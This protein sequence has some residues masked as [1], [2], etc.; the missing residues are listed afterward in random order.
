LQ[1]LK[2]T[3][4]STRTTI[5]MVTHDLTAAQVGHRLLWL[6]DGLIQRDESFAVAAAQ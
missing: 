1:L 5:V 2:R 4:E 6:K 3:C